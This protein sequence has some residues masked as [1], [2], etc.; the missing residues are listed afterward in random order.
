M[1][2]VI[3]GVL[4]QEWTCGFRE[5]LGDLGGRTD[6]GVGLTAIVAEPES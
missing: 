6:P 5:L 1:L 3:P 2:P 4:S